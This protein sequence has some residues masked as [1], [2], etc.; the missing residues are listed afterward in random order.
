MENEVSVK[1]LSVRSLLLSSIIGGTAI[2][3]PLL[4]LS[5]LTGGLSQ[6]DIT[7]E[8]F[9]AIWISIVVAF[10]FSV[11]CSAIGCCFLKVGFFLHSIKQPIVIKYKA[12]A[13]TENL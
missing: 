9:S 7:V 4:I 10:V 2:L 12:A 13:N 5:A 8:G 6:A 11:A 3:A 1:S